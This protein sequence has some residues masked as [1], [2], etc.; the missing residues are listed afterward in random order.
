MKAFLEKLDTFKEQDFDIKEQMQG[1]KNRNKWLAEKKKKEDEV[2]ARETEARREQEA[3][4]KRA[5]ELVS[6]SGNAKAKGS[7]VSESIVKESVVADKQVKENSQIAEL[8]RQNAELQAKLKEAEA[9]SLK[10]AEVKDQQIDALRTKLKEAGVK[11]Q[12]NTELQAKLKEAEIKL[13]KAEASLKGSEAKLQN[14]SQ[15]VSSSQLVKEIEPPKIH[16]V[17]VGP[18]ISLPTASP[19]ITAKVASKDDNLTSAPPPPPIIHS[20]VIK[21]E[22][23]KEEMQKQAEAIVLNDKDFAATLVPFAQNILNDYKSTLNSIW[24]KREN[25]FVEK[26]LKD[27]EGL[28]T[29]LKS[30]TFEPD[31]LKKQLRDFP[32]K[33]H[34]YKEQ[35]E[36]KFGLSNDKKLLD[37]LDGIANT[38]EDRINP[39]QKKEGPT[40]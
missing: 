37:I 34:K 12:Q 39:K 25:N 23:K 40:L 8:N 22:F 32:G 9:K 24:N 28:T 19:A 13:L 35:Y 15:A 17:P 21:E 31:S 10:E 11:D 33:I 36:K 20:V 16:V 27:L 38:V 1:K 18:P 5:Q 14:Q 26:V 2:R 30:E 3:E 29:L 6:K 4:A 7:V